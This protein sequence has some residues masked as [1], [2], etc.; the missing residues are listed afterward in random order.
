MVMVT[1]G[2]TM[3][4]QTMVNHYFTTVTLGLTMVSH[5]LIT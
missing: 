5:G 1:H 2:L 4:N 3:V